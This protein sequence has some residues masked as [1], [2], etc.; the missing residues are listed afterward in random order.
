[1]PVYKEENL[2]MIMLRPVYAKDREALLDY[3]M[4]TLIPE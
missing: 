1:M 2:R 4:E 3:L